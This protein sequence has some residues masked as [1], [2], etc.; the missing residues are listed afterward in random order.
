MR[1]PDVSI[2]VRV[3]PSNIGCVLLLWHVRLPQLAHG[4]TGNRWRM[5]AHP[6]MIG[7]IAWGDADDGEITNLRGSGRVVAHRQSRVSAKTGRHAQDI[8]LRQP[9]LDVDP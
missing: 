4:T 2:S 9:G 3:K 6:G 1:A 5:P 7:A 8:F